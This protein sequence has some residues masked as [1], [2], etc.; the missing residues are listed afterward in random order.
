VLTAVVLVTAVVGLV[1]AQGA[2]R[3]TPGSVGAAIPS[4]PAI[5]AGPST[6]SAG[7][8]TASAGSSTASDIAA[9]RACAAFNTYLADAGKGQIPRTAGEAVTNA[10]Y[11]L[12]AG[13]SQD[14]A[15][16]KHLPQWAKLGEDLIAATDDVVNR[17]SSALSTDGTAA[18]EACQTIPEAARVAG[19]Y[20]LSASP[21]PSR[22]G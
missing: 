17:N 15:A 5:S 18:A 2:S 9:A 20:A 8:S 21:N 13:D 6:A 11:Q 19:G 14:Q 1:L 22:G 12:L 4:T 7:S 3:P 16:G 10:A